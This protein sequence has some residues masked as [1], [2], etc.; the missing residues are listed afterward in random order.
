[1]CLLPGFLESLGFLLRSSDTEVISLHLLTIWH[2]LQE[3]CPFPTVVYTLALWSSAQREAAC[4]L[5]IFFNRG[6]KKTK[7][8][9]TEIF[10]PHSKKRCCV[11][12]KQQDAQQ[13]H[14]ALGLQSCQYPLASGTAESVGLGSWKTEELL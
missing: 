3:L 4:T 5:V 8:K 11:E 6:N 2:L 1:M 12:V 14:W 9:S 13:E 10:H 7:S